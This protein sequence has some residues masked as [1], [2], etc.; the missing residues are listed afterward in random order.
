VQT[1]ANTQTPLSTLLI[2]RRRGSAQAARKA[3][4]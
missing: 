2:R 4:W 1:M 3:A